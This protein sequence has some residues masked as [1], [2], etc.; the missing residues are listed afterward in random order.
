[1]QSSDPLAHTPRPPYYAVVF[2][3]V[4]TDAQHA[5]YAA[6]AARM[7]ELASQQP[8]Y[9]GVESARDEQS[10]I[11]VSYWQ[12]LEAIR[13]WGRVAEHRVAQALGREAWYSSFR[14][15]VCRVEEERMFP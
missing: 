9:L 15:R 11:T 14:L 5:E 10:G 4:R 6:M 8:G 3:S 13:A 1:M 7:V 2:T 12:N